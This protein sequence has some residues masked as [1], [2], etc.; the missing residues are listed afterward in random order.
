MPESISVRVNGKLVA[1]P[2]GA[3][4]AVAVLLSGATCRTSVTGEPR[5]PLCGMGTC[6]ECRV[7]INGQSHSRSCQVICESE[8]EIISNG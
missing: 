4:V 7:A 5:S 3:T 6:F 8:M 2:A 1:V